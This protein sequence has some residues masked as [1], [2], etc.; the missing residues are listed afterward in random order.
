MEETTPKRRPL[1][2][3]RRAGAID[4]F[5]D[6]VLET[7]ENPRPEDVASRAGVSIASLYRYFEN[8]D[9]LR[10]GAFARLVDRFPELFL[11]PEVG[12]GSR[13]AR[14]TAFVE[15]RLA[16]HEKLHPVQLLVRRLRPADAAVTRDNPRYV[17]ADQISLHFADELSP[18]DPDERRAVVAT[19]N[20]VTSTESW[21]HFRRTDD[22]TPDQTRDAWI[23]AI[24]HLLPATPTTPTT[25]DIR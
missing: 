12:T 9:E 22:R 18:L 21:E 24:D 1:P 14:I 6:L 4:A 8:L 10:R 3:E 16:M 23:T 13:Q 20:V 11:I 17:S 2:A 25:E 7:G 15:T 5:I 19:I